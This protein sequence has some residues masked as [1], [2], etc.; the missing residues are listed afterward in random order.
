MEYRNFDLMVDDFD[1][2]KQSF[3]VCVY[4]SPA[5][6][7]E[8]KQD[9]SIANR[10][11][12]LLRETRSLARSHD[13]HAEPDIGRQMLLGQHLFDLIFPSHAR[14]LYE[15]SLMRLHEEQSLRLR[16]RL[17]IELS[18]LP[19]EYLYRGEPGT[20]AI[21]G[22]LALDPRI[23]I[24]RALP[25][26]LPVEWFE[27]VEKHHLIVAMASPRDSANPNRLPTLV[28]LPEE[29]RLIKKLL[30]KNFGISAVF[31]P[32]YDGKG[33]NEV[34]GVTKDKLQSQLEKQKQADIFHFSGHGE[35]KTD[36][37]QSLHTAKG[38][39]YVIFARPNNEPMSVSAD[40][41]AATLKNHGIKLVILG[42]CETA[43]VDIYCAS[44]SVATS[45]VSAG[46]S[47]VVAMQ[48]KVFD[49]LA[50]AFAADLYEAL[51]AGRTIDEA[52]SLGRAAMRIKARMDPRIHADVH[53]WGAPVLYTRSQTG[54]VFGPIKDK[55]LQDSADLKIGLR[56]YGDRLWWAWLSTDCLASDRQIDQILATKEIDKLPPFQTLLLLRSAVASDYP[57]EN[58]LEQLRAHGRQYVSNLDN[59]D[60]TI[61]KE[62]STAMQAEQNL[63]GIHDLPSIPDGIGPVAWSAVSHPDTE[64]RQTAAL[65][66]CA[67]E[68]DDRMNRLDGALQHISQPLL[69]NRRK[70][71]IY[72]ALADGGCRLPP[73]GP[74]DRFGVWW[75]RF[76]RRLR[77]DG[78]RIKRLF[79]HGSIGAG[80]GFAA[81]RLLIAILATGPATYSRA[82]LQF[83][84][85]PYLGFLYAIPITLA[86]GLAGPLLLYPWGKP[87][88]DKTRPVRGEKL[89]AFLLGA[90]GFGVWHAILSFLLET[91]A[92]YFLQVTVLGAIAGAFFNAAMFGQPYASPRKRNSGWVWRLLFALAAL[93][94]PQ[95][96]AYVGNENWATLLN[97]TPSDIDVRFNPHRYQCLLCIMPFWK[98]FVRS[99]SQWGIA[100]SILDAAATGVVFTL[101][102]TF[103]IAGE[104][105]TDDK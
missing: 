46:I 95:L 98:Q 97:L 18:P 62:K 17:P 81:W 6:Q 40:W 89:L 2:S 100:F 35:F 50:A 64:V 7:G 26:A 31:L 23:S 21:T 33:I 99:F 1:T 61:E 88:G 78:P 69:R 47:A 41:L 57:A 74:W 4:D 71:E 73:I 90:L 36:L 15:R 29:Q 51:V 37:G 39:G 27:P 28:N 9:V 53:D 3:T 83:I 34:V 59:K 84:T 56:S 87:T 32:S 105:E 5:G 86:L 82:G 67:L 30:K 54:H 104:E 58:W 20:S 38:K 91:D 101:G 25:K 92:M 13:P 12:S 80:I 77:D 94:V 60:Q 52:V 79:W 75:W 19:W 55:D 70:S 48:F 42:A 10:L 11:N 72:G 63:L 66:L 65:C 68:P 22:F 93:V 14:D 43:K 8:Y 24:V 76:R 103:G 16:L 102:L 85:A 45:L 44:S 49:S 96:L